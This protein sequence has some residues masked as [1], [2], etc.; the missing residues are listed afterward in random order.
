[1]HWKDVFELEAAF[2]DVEKERS[3][4]GSD[5]E[6]DDSESRTNTPPSLQ[7]PARDHPVSYKKRML[8]TPQSPA[9]GH[10]TDYEQRVLDKLGYIT[11]VFDPSSPEGNYGREISVELDG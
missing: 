3:D 2:P 5:T 7:S 8:P 1:V 11:P 10:P 6:S 9:E 4:N